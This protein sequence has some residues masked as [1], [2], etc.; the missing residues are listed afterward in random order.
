M[1]DDGEIRR[2]DRAAARRWQQ[3]LDG[4]SA[5]DESLEKTLTSL[6]ESGQLNLL[7]NADGLDDLPEMKTQT[8]QQ[9]GM[10]I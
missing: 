1:K 3:L 8:L 10:S 4:E 6:R 7:H 2:H 9:L 5:L